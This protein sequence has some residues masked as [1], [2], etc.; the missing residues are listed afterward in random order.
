MYN[1][2]KRVFDE[3]KRKNEDLEKKY[4]DEAAQRQ[5]EKEIKRKQSEEKKKVDLSH[6]MQDT[7]AEQVKFHNYKK[8]G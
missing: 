8:H 5:F 2:Y 6:N 3:R 1:Y 4:I 7:L